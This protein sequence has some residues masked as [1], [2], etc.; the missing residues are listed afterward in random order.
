MNIL[1]IIIAIV[2]ILGLYFVLTQRS[3]VS[4]EERVKNSLSQIGVQMN[5]RWDIIVTLTKLV[6]KYS[7]YEYDTLMDVIAARRGSSV[8]SVDEAQQQEEATS[9]VLGKINAIAEQYPDLKASE[10]YKNT[11]DQINE[12]ENNVRISRQ[13]YNDC[14]TLLNTKVRQWPS[15][16]VANILGINQVEYL[17]VDKEK[18]NIPNV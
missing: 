1:N 14:A 4:L 3:F 15:A 16:L 2:V 11:M 10:L 18:K 8:K 6:E 7:K 5:S 9:A 13:V 12:F 17:Q